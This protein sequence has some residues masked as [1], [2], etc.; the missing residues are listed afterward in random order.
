MRILIPALL[1]VSLAACQSGYVP[2][3]TPLAEYAARPAGRYPFDVQL[4][5]TADTRQRLADLK[6][7][8]TISNM[9]W[10]EPK[11]DAQ[12]HADEMNQISLG[13]DRVDVPP[14]DQTVRISG[15]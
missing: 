13:D 10:G 4:K 5:L 6:E 3:S 15:V 8:I 14:V 2:A 9:F 1:C 12:R 11:A 7:E